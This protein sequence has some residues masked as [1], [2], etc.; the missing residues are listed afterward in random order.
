MPQNILGIDIGSYSI[1]VAQ[2]RRTFKSFELVKFYERQIQFNEI[3]TPEESTQAALTGIIEDNALTWDQV[4][5]GLPG[6][7]V[8]SRLITLPFENKKKIDQTIEFELEN[9][10]PYE[11]ADVVVDY[12]IVHLAKDSSKVLVMYAPKG[13]F[14]K[15]L[16]LLENAGI[17]PRIVCVEGVALVNLVNLGMVPPEG[18][19][20]MVDIGHRKTTVT[21]CKGKNLVYTRMIMVGG[22]HFTNSISAKAGVPFD[23]AEK[24]KIEM[25]QVNVEES[26]MIDDLSK[27]IFSGIKTAADD[28]VLHLRQTFFAYQDEEGEAV[29]GIYLSGGTS[30]LPGLDRFL[31]IKLKQNVAF[32][33]C[34]EFHFSRLTSSDVH[35]Q[36]IPQA[37]ALALRGV[38]PAGLPEINFR[39]GEFAYKGDVKEVGSGI[40]RLAA[41]LAVLII[42]PVSYFGIRY[43]SL[44]NKLSEI[45]KDVANL[46]LQVIPDINQKKIATASAALSA[47]KARGNEVE[48]RLAKLSSVLS[49]SSL[50]VLKDASAAF[51]ERNDVQVN[52]EDFNY[53]GGRIKMSGR[54]TS[55]EA[56]DKIKAALERSGKFKN[57]AT[58]NVRKGVKE[59]IKF[60]ITM[61]SSKSLEA[62]PVEGKPSGKSKEARE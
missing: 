18:V 57:V 60:D 61:D 34:L 25:G 9:Y 20:A 49:S 13:S 28:L 46:V 26:G 2:I 7:F 11:L 27:Q 10:I 6:Q 8:S 62:K 37:L 12:H 22:Y 1:K 17:D 36:L 51:P 52:I 24:L 16:T 33:D 32:L 31:S 44:S 14:V 5:V 41:A 3:L 19:Y 56:V 42:L 58:A 30:R 35:L 29:S 4:I 39:R 40:R 43:V 23:E 59:E 21:I 53:Q 55:F 50:E 48:D 47:V 54:T 15:Y 38:A 45:N